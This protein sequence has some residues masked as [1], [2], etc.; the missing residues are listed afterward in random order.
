M[1]EN[2]GDV[3][4]DDDEPQDNVGYNSEMYN[5]FDCFRYCRIDWLIKVESCVELF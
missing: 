2:K 3:D 4:E 5:T 1:E